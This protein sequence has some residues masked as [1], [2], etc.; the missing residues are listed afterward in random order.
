MPKWLRWATGA[1]IL[2]LVACALDGPLFPW[3]PVKPGYTHFVLHRADVY[4]PSGTALDPAYQQI[5]GYIEDAEA[6][7]RLKMQDRITVIA[8]RSWTD[9]H[10]Q[11]PSERGPVAGITYATGMVI[12]ITPKVVEKRADVGEYLRHELSHAILFQNMTMWKAHQMNGQPWLLEG[13]AVDFGRQK[14]YLSQEEFA[15]AARTRAL[16]PSFAGDNSDM[17]FNYIAWR[18]FLEFLIQTRG[19]D[20]FQDYL[21]RV[22][23]DP[24]QARAVFPEYFAK[25]FD[26]AVAEFQASYTNGL[27]IAT[28]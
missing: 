19:R 26:A 17:R 18:T 27:T 16:G 24:K 13:L 12:F 11:V 4:Y 1:A 23:Q 6:F 10:L 21:L 8:P 3:S 20:K 14:S 7:H 22:M 15:I 2:F 25:P 5:D 9:F 28:P